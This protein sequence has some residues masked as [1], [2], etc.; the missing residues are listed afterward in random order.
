MYDVGGSAFEDYTDYEQSSG[1]EGPSEV[2]GSSGVEGSFESSGSSGCMLWGV[3]KSDMLRGKPAY[4][5]R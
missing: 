5:A 4:T 3:K 1:V 2:E